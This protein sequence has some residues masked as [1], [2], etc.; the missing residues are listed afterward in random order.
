MM[1][2]FGVYYLGCFENFVEANGERP[3]IKLGGLYGKGMRI[4]TGMFG[5]DVITGL[6][7]NFGDYTVV[8]ERN[9]CGAEIV[10]RSF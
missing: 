7:V 10:S 8:C 3:G 1:F 9:T 2:N 6:V 5:G 4:N